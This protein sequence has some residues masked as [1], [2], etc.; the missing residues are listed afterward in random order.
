VHGAKRPATE[1][2]NFNNSN[3]DEVFSSAHDLINNDAPFSTVFEAKLLCMP[4]STPFVINPSCFNE[5]N[6]QT[7]SYY[8]RSLRI[9]LALRNV[10]GLA[11]LFLAGGLSAV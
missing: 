2:R 7:N 11:S 3:D 1:T 9:D 8:R 5:R 6:T 4:R 10:V